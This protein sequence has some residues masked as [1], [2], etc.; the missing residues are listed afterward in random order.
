MNGLLPL[1]S[2]VVTAALI[3][4]VLYQRRQ[5]LRVQ[6]ALD[7]IVL[8]YLAL[9]ET[10]E[11]LVRDV[12]EPYGGVLYALQDLEAL[13]TCLAAL[14]GGENPPAAQ[15]ALRRLDD[16]LRIILIRIAG[17]YRLTPEERLRLRARGVTR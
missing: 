16:L 15:A 12:T 17:R 11:S 3:M 10:H 8:R 13:R 14:S 6:T 1:V 4:G 2:A 7:G 9:T 5:R